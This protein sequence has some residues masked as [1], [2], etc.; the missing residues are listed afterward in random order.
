M[1]HVPS[2]SKICQFYY[3]LTVD[4]NVSTFYITVNN[5]ALVHVLESFKHLLQNVL[6]LHFG[7]DYGLLFNQLL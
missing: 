3:A 5:P 6:E 4:E 2:K 1:Y 7:E